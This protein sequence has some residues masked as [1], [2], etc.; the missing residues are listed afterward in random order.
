M[1]STTEVPIQNIYMDTVSQY[2]LSPVQAQNICLVNESVCGI[3][4]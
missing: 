3:L 4:I 2:L 1:K